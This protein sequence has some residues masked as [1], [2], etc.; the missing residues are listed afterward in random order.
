MI[1]RVTICFT[2]VL[3]EAFIISNILPKTETQ[4]GVRGQPMRIPRLVVGDP[5]AHRDQALLPYLALLPLFV[6]RDPLVAF[7]KIQVPKID[8]NKL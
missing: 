4:A 2:N 5:F 7:G 3:S 6:S 1:T 8:I